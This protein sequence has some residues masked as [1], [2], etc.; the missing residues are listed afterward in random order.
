[1][2]RSRAVIGMVAGFVKQALVDPKAEIITIQEDTVPYP[3]EEEDLVN[4]FLYI[5][6]RDPLSNCLGSDVLIEEHLIGSTLALSTA[7][8]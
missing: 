4:G 2:T 3:V 7:P 6:V 8:A 5:M 1:M